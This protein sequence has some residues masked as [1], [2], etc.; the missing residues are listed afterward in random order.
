MLKPQH[1]I[2]H[3]LVRN[4]QYVEL[5][6]YNT[7]GDRSSVVSEA[8]CKMEETRLEK[9]AYIKKAILRVRN[10]RECLYGRTLFRMA[11][12]NVA[13]KIVAML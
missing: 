1:K 9:R 2:V 7:V 10:A 8:S 6:Y 12:R 5:Y 11:S 3:H 13:G 4:L